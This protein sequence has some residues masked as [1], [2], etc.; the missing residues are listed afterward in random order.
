MPIFY[1][2]VARVLVQYGIT[3]HCSILKNTR[4]TEYGHICVDLGR[5]IE[6][7]LTTWVGGDDIYM[8]TSFEA[9][10]EALDLFLSLI[11]S[12]P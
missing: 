11:W 8:C 10:A 1:S 3:C 5:R 12:V 6:D 9:D 2:T 4:F 7:A